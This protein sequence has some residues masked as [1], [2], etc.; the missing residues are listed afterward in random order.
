MNKNLTLFSI[1]LFSFSLQGIS[2]DVLK[3]VIERNQNGD[4]KKKI[5]QYMGAVKMNNSNEVWNAVVSRE[6]TTF[7][8]PVLN[9]GH[10]KA[11]LKNKNNEQELSS[12]D[13]SGLFAALSNGYVEQ[14]RA[15]EK[16]KLEAEAKAVCWRR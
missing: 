13:A 5:I 6:F 7:L 10:Y 1:S 16:A 15:R 4:D 3:S 9:D 14:E 12:W 2:F 11:K 8:N